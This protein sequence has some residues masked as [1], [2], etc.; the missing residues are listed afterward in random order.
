MCGIAGIW[1][2]DQNQRVSPEII[3]RMAN[4]LQH[5]G[6]D[7]EGYLLV[8]TSFRHY[9]AFSGEDTIPEF[10][11]TKYCKNRHGSFAG[12]TPLQIEPLYQT[13]S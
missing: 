13:N 8:N 4:T 12:K 1:Y 11:T 9:Q 3:T 6:P 10:E 2:L 5:R 7:D